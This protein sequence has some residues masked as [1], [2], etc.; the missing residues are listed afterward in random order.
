MCT[1]YFGLS[2]IY[3]YNLLACQADDNMDDIVAMYPEALSNETSK[4]HIAKVSDGWQACLATPA[5]GAE[6]V[7]FQHV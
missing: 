7:K 6:V 2:R 1:Y 5:V 3:R 4:H